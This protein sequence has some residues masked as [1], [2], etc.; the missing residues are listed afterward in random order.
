MIHFPRKSLAKQFIHDL[1][2]KNPIS[3]APNGLFLAAP[4]RTGKSMFLRHDLV[5][6]F[7]ENGIVPIYVDLWEHRDEDPA[8]LIAGVIGR[9]ARDERSVIQVARDSVRASVNIGPV[10]LEF[11]DSKIGKPGG[12]SIPEAL[13]R[14]HAATG[15]PVALIV[16]EA[17]NALTSTSGIDA[18]ASLKSARDQM[19]S[20]SKI[21]VMLVMSG[22]DRDK[23][24]RL[25][26]SNAAPFY[27]S[28]I[29]KMPTLSRDY[30]E[31]LA[32]EIGR[33]HKKAKPIDVDALFHAFDMYGYRPQFLGNGILAALD[34]TQGTTTFNEAILRHAN[35]TAAAAAKEMT[36]IFLGL[37]ELQRTLLWRMFS[38]GGKFRPF[39]ADALK[40]Y[41]KHT[42]EKIS[43]A[44]A[45]SALEGL[46]NGEDP[47]IW[48]SARGEYSVNDSGMVRWFKS[49]NEESKW[50]PV[51]T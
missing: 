17:Q 2:G 38:E 8:V 42:G 28:Q 48:K 34:E 27:G 30:I 4:R 10:E 6:E 47:L 25:V 29:T 21:N 31:A 26:N 39:D 40:F 20:P 3:D 5:P 45:Q 15:K 18:M 46:R 33:L 9:R 7:A 13:Q 1:S 19:N 16:D 11:D 22:S 41:S 44:H 51:G 35:N 36:S 24:L 32:E 12:I 23:L 43:V 49:L 37:S 50:P 14:I